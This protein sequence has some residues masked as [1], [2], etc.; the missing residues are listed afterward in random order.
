MSVLIA[1]SPH[2]IAMPVSWTLGRIMCLHINSTRPEEHDSS[3]RQNSLRRFGLEELCALRRWSPFV[4]C[5]PFQ[6]EFPLAA[7]ED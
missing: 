6:F 4:P 2:R 7:V 5:R 1:V 3:L